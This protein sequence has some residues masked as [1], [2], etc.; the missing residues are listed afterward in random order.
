MKYIKPVLLTLFVLTLTLCGYIYYK[1]DA[2]YASNQAYIAFKDNDLEKSSSHIA[3]LNKK[4]NPTY[5][6]YQGYVDLE[7]KKYHEAQTSF[8]KA[9]LLTKNNDLKP[10]ISGALFLS[11]FL[12]NDFQ[13]LENFLNQDKSNSSVRQLFEGILQYH[14]SDFENSKKSLQNLSNPLSESKWLQ[15]ELERHINT[16]KLTYYLSHSMI[17]SGQA[18]KARQHLE[19][20]IE[21]TH[22]KEP[23][24]YYLIGLSF[25]KEA[26]NKPLSNT[27][28]YYQTAFQ[29]FRQIPFSQTTYFEYKANVVSYYEKLIG[30]IL[31]ESIYQELG[32]FLDILGYFDAKVSN[33]AD[34][35]LTHIKK[36]VG[37]ENKA[38]LFEL[39]CQTLAY[40]HNSSFKEKLSASFY[41]Y[42]QNLVRERQIDSAKK[43]WPIYSQISAQP[44]E[45]QIAL[46][47]S[48]YEELEKELDVDEFNLEK[49]Q[50]LLEMLGAFNLSYKQKFELLEALSPKIEQMWIS[51][52][53]KAWLFSKSLDELI[54]SDNSVDFHKKMNS[55]LE[56]FQSEVDLKEYS[57]K[58]PLKEAN[59]YFQCVENKE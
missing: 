27:I 7:Q 44:E 40:C 55:L 33:I 8:K 39:S 34:L 12:L 46:S 35:F 31:E 4:S 53:Q 38:K 2:K 16:E 43:A 58:N 26:E 45:D 52:G 41:F 1:F 28:P 20:F 6:L 23:S 57:F 32:C 50:E 24:L 56:Q 22:S 19:S 36:E 17:E 9:K 48:V 5:Y 59:Q 49:S 14:K 13:S 18:H 30:S 47:Q 10:E 29:Y 37:L 11:A 15:T 51:S 54:F 3:A 21:S 42:I 25:L